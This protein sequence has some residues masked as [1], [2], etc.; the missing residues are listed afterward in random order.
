MKRTNGL[1]A[2]AVL[3][4]S[5]SG[6]AGQIGSDPADDRSPPRYLIGYV[7]NGPE[8]LLGGG[9]A[10]LPTFLN[11][12]GVHA[13]VKT[14]IDSPANEEGYL[15]DVSAEE[16]IEFGDVRRFLE[17]SYT[18]VNVAVVRAISADL[19]VYAG[20]GVAFQT[21]YGEFFDDT[22]TRSNSGHYWAKYENEGGTLPTLTGGLF[23]RLN[24]LIIVQFGAESLPTGM[25]VGVHV[26]F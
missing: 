2:A 26:G 7:V 10:W 22:A 17:A 6:L 3:L 19:L 18:S 23:F 9:V 21:V 4:L 20:G 16:A 12:W 8:Q 24:P 13:T 11:G 5:A 15:E 14:D 1:A 25:V